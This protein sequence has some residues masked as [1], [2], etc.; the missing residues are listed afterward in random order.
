[1]KYLLTLNVLT[2]VF[3]PTFEVGSVK[4]LFLSI[5]IDIVVSSA[6]YLEMQRI[7]WRRRN[8]KQTANKMFFRIFPRLKCQLHLNIYFFV[9]KVV[10]VENGD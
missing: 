5:S 4:K 9:F 3:E 6:K 1:M 2:K 7:A 8:P 10:L